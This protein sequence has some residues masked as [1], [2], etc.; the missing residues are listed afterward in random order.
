MAKVRGVAFCQVWF[1]ESLTTMGRIETVA[2]GKSLNGSAWGSERRFVDIVKVQRFQPA[3]KVKVVSFANNQDETCFPNVR[4][5]RILAALLLR[6]V[7]VSGAAV[8]F[9]VRGSMWFERRFCE[10]GGHKLPS[11][12]MLKELGS[13]SGRGNVRVS[14]GMRLYRVSMAWSER[15]CS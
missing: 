1:L 11:Q 14:R 4:S 10:E 8:K 6:N 9:S 2:T 5:L 15:F 12:W 13:V 3:A 7:R